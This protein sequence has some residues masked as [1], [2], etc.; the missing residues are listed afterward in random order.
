MPSPP[1]FTCTLGH[2]AKSLI[3][4]FHSTK[5]ASRLPAYGPRPIAPPTW[6]STIGVADRAHLLR[7][8]SA[9]HRQPFEIDRRGD[10]VAAA[11]VGE[12]LRQQIAPGIGA[13]DQVMVRVDDRQ[14]GFEDLLLPQS[15]PVAAHRRVRR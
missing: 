6:S 15:Q 4:L 12:Q 14:L 5:T 1:S 9:V 3:L 7:T 2:P 11:G 8:T 13:L 10:V